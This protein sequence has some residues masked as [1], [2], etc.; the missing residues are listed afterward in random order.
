MALGLAG[1]QGTF[2][3]KILDT[4]VFLGEL[5][6][7]GGVRSVRGALS[8][9]LAARE[10]G[11]K[12]VAVPESK[13]REAAVVEGIR[14]FGVKSLPQAVD[15]VNAP[16]SF[17]PVEV[18]TSQMLSEANQYSVDMRDVRGQM[19]AKRALEVACAGGHNILL[20]GP[21]GAGK[22]MLAKRI[23][24]ILPPMSLDEAIETTRIH[25][26]AGVLEDARGLVGTRPYRSPHHTISD[27]GLIGGGAIPRPG[28][29]SLGHNGVLFL[30]ELPEFQRNVLE[31]MRQPLE[32]GSVTIARAA[33][34]VNFPSRFMLAAAMNPCPCGFFG[35]NTREC[36]CSPIQ[37]QRYVSKIS[38]PLLDRI[39]IHIEVPA[40][41][42]KELRGDVEVE[43]SAAVRERVL[44][45]R[46]IQTKRYA[47]RK[48]NLF[49]F[50]DAP[51]VD[52]QKLRHLRRRRKTPRNRHPAPRPFRPRPRPHPKSRPHHRRPRSRRRHRPKT[53]ERGHSIPHA[54]SYLL[55]LRGFEL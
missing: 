31:V 32:D 35:D 9:A 51:E 16:E 6:L 11:I 34:S 21:P 1:C 27:A 22:T 29:V 38:G 39:D 3:G 10:R 13:A 2:F 18:D 33:L 25:S 26:V 48:E 52:P 44:R 55:G 12:N 28:E 15:L 40:V 30:D 43:S 54:G 5:S 47:R 41:K 46:E 17:K 4:H 37:I 50:A 36:H 49:E 45:A 24:T 23:P 8:A 20:I 14:V 19:S 42:Y 53:F 7:D